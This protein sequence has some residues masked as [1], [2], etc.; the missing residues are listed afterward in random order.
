M[1]SRT[2]SRMPPPVPI[3]G[4]ETQRRPASHEAPPS[5][6]ASEHLAEAAPESLVNIGQ[7]GEKVYLIDIDQIASSKYQVGTMGDEEYIEALM[8]SIKNEGLNN[9]AIIRKNPG[10]A[11]P[12]EFVAGEHRAI[13]YSRLGHKQMPCLL[14]EYSNEQAAKSLVS[15]N[16]HRR[17]QHDYDRYKQYVML[18]ENGFCKIDREAADILGIKASHVSFIRAF[19]KLPPEALA[20]I[21]K[22]PSRIS[23]STAYAIR[24][25]SVTHPALVTE[26]IG[27]VVSKE[28]TQSS[29]ET[30]LTKEVAQANAKPDEATKKPGRRE[31]KI[32]GVNGR[33]DIRIVSGGGVTKIMSAGLDDDK[34][35]KLIQDNVGALYSGD[36]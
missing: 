22:N 24:E 15:D 30:W 17:Q 6:L 2:I 7:A 35:F 20:I 23:A 16:A 12:Y 36:V 3:A 8:V 10:A 14:R 29:L 26:G 27:L 4:L 13:V 33:P 28:L 34:L 32:R 21:E 1:K 18:M 11:R 25:F 5:A 19:A 31:L 9:P